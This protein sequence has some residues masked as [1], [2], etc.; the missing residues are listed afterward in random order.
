M[1]VPH[2][3][4]LRPSYS[5]IEASLFENPVKRLGVSG[6]TA[7]F[8]KLKLL[9]ASEKPKD[10]YIGKDL[11]RAGDELDFYEEVKHCRGLPIAAALWP[12]LD[13]TF[14][15]AGIVLQNLHCGRSRLRLLDVKIGQKTAQGGWRGKSHAAAY[16]QAIVDGHTNSSGEGFRLEGFDGQPS[17]L[18]SMDRGLAN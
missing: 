16:R 7:P 18:K 12:L 5:R 8:F 17:S 2:T 1:L 11:S 14:D 3:R 9:D 4:G 6:G 15:Y 13:F 10:Y